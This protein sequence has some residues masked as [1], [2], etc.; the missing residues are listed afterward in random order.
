M[1]T[2]ACRIA[3]ATLLANGCGEPVGVVGD[4]SSSSAADTTTTEVATESSSSSGTADE[5]SS[6]GVAMPTSECGN[7]SLEFGEDCD[8]GKNGDPDDGC[9]D[10]CTLPTCGDGWVQPSLGEAC[11][12]GKGGDV[13]CGSECGSRHRLQWLDQLGTR[14][15]NDDNAR[16]VA[17]DPAGNVIAVGDV[18]AIGDMVLGRDIWVRKYDPAGEVL[19][20]RTHDSGVAAS[21][22]FGDAVTT[23]A[24]GNVYVAGGMPVMGNGDDAFVI[25]Y[26]PDGAQQWITSHQ[27]SAGND[28]FFQAIV[29]TSDGRLLVGGYAFEDP[30][31][32]AVG[33]Y[34][35]LDQS[36][37]AVVFSDMVVATDS[38]F[39]AQIYDVAVGPDGELALAGIVD[40]DAFVRVLEPDGSER[41]SLVFDAI[42]KDEDAARGVAFTPEGDVLV[43]GAGLY[44]YLRR[45]DADGAELWSQVY[46]FAEASSRGVGITTDGVVVLIGDDSSLGSSGRTPAL[47]GIDPADGTEVWRNAPLGG[48]V[49]G[50]G[51]RLATGPGGAFAAVGSA[52]PHIFE[53]TD[54]WVV[55]YLPK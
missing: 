40:D 38:D 6:S 54:L 35:L 14:E 46:G 16:G 22:D 50:N 49:I 23:D 7:G 36:D 44:A 3:A 39:Y 30:E 26:D 24:D 31:P 1:R 45:F 48:A 13:F 20:T 17:I 32:S 37:G 18:D 29:A 15:G 53:G 27:G 8:D 5:S 12:A 4:G 47:F 41:W 9:T 19:W 33:W 11:D 21:N 10:D 43:T 25:A 52:T 34:G 28:D 42:E 51:A 2:I 55:S